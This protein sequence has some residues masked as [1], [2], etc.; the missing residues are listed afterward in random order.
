MFKNPIAGSTRAKNNGS[1][2]VDSGSDVLCAENTPVLAAASGDIIYSEYPTYMYSIS[3][4]S[5][6]F[7]KVLPQSSSG[8]W[9]WGADRTSKGYGR[10][11]VGGRAGGPQRAHRVAY[12]MLVGPITEGYVLDHVICRNPRCVNPAHL[13]PVTNEEN[14]R[15]GRP[16][17]TALN[18]EKTHCRRGHPYDEGNTYFVTD[19]R[20]GTKGRGCKECNRARGRA[21]WQKK[22]EARLSC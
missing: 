12:E 13:E 10:F 7:R 22:K 14:L 19:R 18:R 3:D 21:N 5:R 16:S 6:F 1:Y 2:S 17:P 9:H 15:R 8:C 11:S 20:T 4:I